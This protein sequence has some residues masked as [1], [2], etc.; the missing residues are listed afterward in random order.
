MKCNKKKE[1]RRR[2]GGQMRE[3][4]MLNKNERQRKRETETHTELKTT[5]WMSIITTFII[6]APMLTIL[7]HTRIPV[8]VIAPIHAPRYVKM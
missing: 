3:K 1:K 8:A 2:R 7:A 6:L 5:K 4:G